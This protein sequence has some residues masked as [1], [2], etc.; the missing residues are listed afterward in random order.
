MTISLNCLV[1]IQLFE[2]ISSQAAFDFL[3]SQTYESES[4]SPEFVS[5]IENAISKGEDYH[6]PDNS[7]DSSTYYEWLKISPRLSEI[8][9]RPYLHLTKEES[10][11]LAAYDELSVEAQ[12]ILAALLEAA[13]IDED[14]QEGLRLIGID[15][16]S[17]IFDRLYRRAS[18]EQFPLSS[19]KSLINLPLAFSQHE[20]KFILI[21]NE[22]PANKRSAPLMPTLGR[23]SWCKNLLIEWSK[24]DNTPKKVQGAIKNILEDE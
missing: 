10:G 5:E 1:K 11:S 9:L 20:E 23:F 18:S 12:E 2:R 15:E 21:L 6:S 16:S 22:I 3:Y 4:G 13:E 7:W 8:D 19:I 14:L 24:D 17:K